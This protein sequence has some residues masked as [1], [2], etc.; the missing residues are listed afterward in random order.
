[1]SN[2]IERLRALIERYWDIA[3]IEG[4]ENRHHDTEEG[5]A[6]NC[7]SEIESI[8]NRLSRPT[9]SGGMPEG[10]VLV[11]IE[12]T[13][14]M[15]YAA[16]AVLVAPGGGLERGSGPARLYRA[17][18][19][20]APQAPTTRP[21][22]TGA[23]VPRV[24]A[25]CHKCHQEFAVP[26][27]SG[28]NATNDLLCNF[29]DCPHCNTRNDLWIKLTTQPT[30]GDKTVALCEA[31]AQFQDQCPE[32]N[33][34]AA[35]ACKWKGGLTELTVRHTDFNPNQPTGGEWVRCEKCKPWVPEHSPKTS[36]AELES[37]RFEF[38][39]RLIYSGEWY[40]VCGYFAGTIN[41]AIDR[42]LEA[43]QPPQDRE[44]GDA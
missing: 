34:I 33:Y 17:M 3:W 40:E 27:K 18:L 30:G 37:L 38:V 5:D 6:Q 21:T 19:D 4:K 8:L 9:S 15:M 35:S 28:G 16:D 11:P 42:L 13:D 22:A 43:H 36:R 41:S 32:G 10:Y 12:P 24:L 25:L 14:A 2:D 23:G 29:C 26:L 44:G 7:L 39:N 20:A 31:L 1:M